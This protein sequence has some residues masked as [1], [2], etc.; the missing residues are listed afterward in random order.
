MKLENNAWRCDSRQILLS[1]NHAPPTNTI[2]QM[3]A[4][5]RGRPFVHAL[6]LA[7]SNDVTRGSRLATLPSLRIRRP[8]PLEQS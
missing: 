2:L 1:L 3:T 4:V 5:G 8:P 6:E 7:A